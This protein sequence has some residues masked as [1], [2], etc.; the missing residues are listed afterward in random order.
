MT[1]G[2]NWGDR[3]LLLGPATRGF[4]VRQAPLLAGRITDDFP[5]VEQGRG[6]GP[7]WMLR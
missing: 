3:A 1:T 5:P 2:S 4:V 6:P 7:S